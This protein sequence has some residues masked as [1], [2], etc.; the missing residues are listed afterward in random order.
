MQIPNKP[1]SKL[2]G[3]LWR[4]GG[5]GRRSFRQQISNLNSTSN[6][7]VALP[8]YWA[9]RFSPNQ[10]EGETSSNVHVPRGNDVI[11]NVISANQHFAS[12]FSMQI[13]K[14]QRRIARSPFLSSS[15]PEQPG[16]LARGM[17]LTYTPL[18][19]LF[20]Q[21]PIPRLKGVLQALQYKDAINLLITCFTNWLN[22]QVQN[23]CK[24]RELSQPSDMSTVWELGIIIITVT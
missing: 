19:F 3:A 23:W 5:K 6:S 2:S 17:Y 21:I 10:R 18:Y 11:T 20:S 4:R 16:Q 1:A 14:F 7:P 12:T 8:V 22:I 15:P 9:V 13:I 24:C